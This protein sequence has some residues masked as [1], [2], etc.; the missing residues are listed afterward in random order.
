M[1]DGTTTASVTLSDD[2]ISGD[3]FSDSYTSALF[4]DKNVA[5]GKTVNVSGI[6]ITGGTDAGNYT[7]NGVTTTTTAADITK[8]DLTVIEQDMAIRTDHEDI[9]PDIRTA[10]RRAQWFEMMDL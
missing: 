1:Y 5:N 2:R 8:R 3:V 7:L 4:A 10:I 6:S 9:G